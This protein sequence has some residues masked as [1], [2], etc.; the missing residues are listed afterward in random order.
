[1]TIVRKIAAPAF[2]AV[3]TLGTA[4]SL[5]APAFASRDHAAVEHQDK[6]DRSHDK[7]D[8]TVS[9]DHSNR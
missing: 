8:K 4:L 1:M 9:R 2:A 5:A 6:Q 3:F 7:G